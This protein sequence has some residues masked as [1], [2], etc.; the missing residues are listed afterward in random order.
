MVSP[1]AESEYTIFQA[2]SPTGLAVQG[3]RIG[4]PIVAGLTLGMA[5]F[6]LISL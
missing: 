1:E 6:I 5:Y 4:Q 3:L 2:I